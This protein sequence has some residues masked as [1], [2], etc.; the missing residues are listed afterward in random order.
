MGD[1]P[2]KLLYT[3]LYI[4]YSSS[5]DLLMPVVSRITR[6][7]CNCEHDE[8]QENNREYIM[9]I[10]PY[11]NID[12]TYNAVVEFIKDYNNGKQ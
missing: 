11:G 7:E 1:K 5:W 2:K 10:I 4:D 6:G 8:N 9:D 12:D 3:T